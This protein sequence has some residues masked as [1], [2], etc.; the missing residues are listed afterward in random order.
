LARIA[1]LGLAYKENT[2]STKNSPALALIDRL[3]GRDVRVHDPVVPASVAPQAT[4]CADALTCVDGVDALVLAT[5]WPEYRELRIKDL[6]R[7]MAGRVLIDPFR[8][9]DGAAAVR[10][11]FEYYALGMPPLLPR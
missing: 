2:H 6:P 7:V 9:L 8:L 11:G 5:P 4:G 10:A 1:V 3:R